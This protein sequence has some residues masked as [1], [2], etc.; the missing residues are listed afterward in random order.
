MFLIVIVAGREQD[1]GEESKAQF[2]DGNSTDLFQG[3]YDNQGDENNRANEDSTETP[4]PGFETSDFTADDGQDEFQEPEV[5]QSE[6]TMDQE[7]EINQ[8]Y[9][10]THLKQEPQEEQKFEDS[11]SHQMPEE[12]SSQ[13]NQQEESGEVNCL[14]KI[15]GKCPTRHYIFSL[16]GVVHIPINMDR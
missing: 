5:Q 13:R 6:P 3:D 7:D 15:L 14:N 9:E 8:G 2:D 10:E 12:V 4:A 11:A 1:S 16:Q